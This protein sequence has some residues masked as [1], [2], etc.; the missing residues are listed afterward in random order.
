MNQSLPIYY[1]MFLAILFLLGG[2][3]IAYGWTKSQ[4]NL[5]HF[6]EDSEESDSAK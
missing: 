3:L 2:I 4:I 6:E 1:Q 5:K